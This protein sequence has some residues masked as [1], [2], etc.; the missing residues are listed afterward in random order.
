[1]RASLVFP[2]GLGTQPSQLYCCSSPVF[3]YTVEPVCSTGRSTGS[4]GRFR[5]FDAGLL[6]SICS[7]LWALPIKLANVFP[8]VFTQAYG[9]HRLDKRHGK[10]PSQR[11]APGGYQEKQMTVAYEQC[12]LT[13]HTSPRH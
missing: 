3:Q 13:T 12:S 8:R 1:M 9:R 11:L 2:R 6:Y 7:V 10:G 5:R 4:H